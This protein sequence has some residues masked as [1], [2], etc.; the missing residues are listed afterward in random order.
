[1]DPNHLTSSENNIAHLALEIAQGQV[2]QSEDPRGSN[3]GPMVD[4]Y[5]AA[6]GLNPGFAWC[7]AFV[8]WCY[9]EAAKKL[10]TSNPVLKTAGVYDCWNRTSTSTGSNTMKLTKPAIMKQPELLQPG[11]QFIL[12]FGKSAGHT[13]FIERV[14]I[15]TGDIMIHTIEGNS[16]NDGSR[17]GYEV[18]RHV[19]KLNEKALQGFIKYAVHHS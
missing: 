7:Q 18:V 19:R 11:D 8:Y 16:N 12:T 5:L 14:D 9:N 2:G 10:G 1:M 15:T 17:E 13:G 3:R 6:T 4:Q